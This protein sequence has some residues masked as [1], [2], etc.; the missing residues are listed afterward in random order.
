MIRINLL[1]EEP[2]APIITKEE[3]VVK[4]RK[5]FPM[6]SLIGLFV[7]VAIAL[8][9]LQLNAIKKERN[10]LNVA[11]EEKNKLKDVLS[12]LETVQGQQDLILRKI[13]LI[14][15]LKAKQGIA[16]TILD[17]LSKQIPQWVW[18]TEVSFSRQ[19]IQVRGRATDNSVIADYVYNLETSP[20]FTNVDLKSTTRRTTRNNEYFDFS[21]SAAYVVPQ[22][23]QPSTKAELKGAN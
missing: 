3:E 11:E 22:V 9:Y 1:K 18:L 21:L 13:E 8:G 2:K 23:P 12:K 19:Q 15:Q 7:I 16:V 10:L 6:T 14:N 17:E 4:E 20:Y 5:P